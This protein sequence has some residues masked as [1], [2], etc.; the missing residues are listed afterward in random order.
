[1]RLSVAIVCKDSASTIGRTLDS[2]SDLADEIVA[3]DS[4]S[5]DATLDML[6][7]AD[8]RIIE[9]D[10]LGYVKTK[11]LALDSCEGDWILALDSDESLLPELIEGIKAA[12]E[13]PGEHTGFE[14]NRKV[15]IHGKALDHAWQ[16]EHRLRL[17]KG[18]H[19][20]WQGLDPHDHLAPIDPGEPISRLNGD[21]RHD[22]I[23]T[24]PEFLEKQHRHAETMARSMLAEGRKPSRFKLLT[25]PAA[26]LLKQ[27]I[28]RQAFL[29]GADGFRAAFATAKAAK[30]KHKA[31]FRLS[32][33]PSNPS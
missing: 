33:G 24:W 6:R 23:S 32:K 19:Y 31:L 27:L 16:P 17:V 12:L 1:M 13:S 14:V 29:D 10:W 25:S 18:G 3:V 26:A 4:G 9:S 2:V 11:Q 20:H 8:A 30:L 7:E 15:F 5:T 21:L 28:L 22:S